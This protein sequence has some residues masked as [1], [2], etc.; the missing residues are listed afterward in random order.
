MYTVRSLIVIVACFATAA[1]KVAEPVSPID[2]SRD[3]TIV[4]ASYGAA[5]QQRL[6]LGLP[7]NRN[8]GT[9]L[10]VV[11][12][13]GGWV[14]G[15]KSEL[16]GL[17]IG[18]K[19]RGYA[20]ANMNYRLAPQAGDNYAMQLDDI[21][22]AI[23]WLSSRGSTLKFSTQR[24][25]LVGHSAGAHLALSYAYTRNSARKIKAVG[26][27]AGPSDLYTLVATNPFPFDWQAVVTPLLTTPLLPLTTASEAKY[28]AASPIS[29]VTATSPPTIIFH[30]D[31]DP[32]VPL[33][34]A[35][36]LAVRLA[37]LGVDQKFILYGPLIGHVWWTDAIRV[38]DTLDQLAL[39]F[40]NHT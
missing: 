15:D 38:T 40:R 17:L 11:V 14:E 23:A 16:N 30:G 12:H 10:V 21:G 22:A 34:Q 1:C 39:W 9:P 31:T 13:G 5:P 3:T 29:T 2:A 24:I 7:S 8:E 36:S 27:L 25:Y 6:D 4:N 33:E 18:L 20:V 37:T 35:T 19:L 26:S 32:R 28:R